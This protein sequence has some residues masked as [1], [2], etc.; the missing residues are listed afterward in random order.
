MTTTVTRR[1]FTVD[2]YHRLAEAGILHED[3]RIELI[4]GEL[5]VMAP[6]GGRHIWSVNRLNELLVTALAGRAI[7]SVQNPILLSNG[8]EPQ[9]DL[10]VLRRPA[11][12]APSLPIPADVFLLVEVADSSL[13]YDLEVKLPLYAAA[14]VDELWIVDL[15]GDQLHR[16]RDPSAS[17]YRDTALLVR[18]AVISPLAFPDIVLDVDEILG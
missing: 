11:R 18:D 6:I 15:Q 12:G 16:Y 5:F 10:A 9:P 13:G 4:E 7:V 8:S 2:E 1:R 14:E 17:G 3:D